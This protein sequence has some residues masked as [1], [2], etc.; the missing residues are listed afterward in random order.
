MSRLFYDICY[1]NSLHDWKYYFACDNVFDT[2]KSFNIWINFQYLTYTELTSDIVTYV[3]KFIFVNYQYSESLKNKCGNC[4]IKYV[5]YWIKDKNRNKLTCDNHVNIDK[6]ANIGASCY[7]AIRYLLDND[8]DCSFC[9]TEI[10]IPNDMMDIANTIHLSRSGDLF[11]G[12]AFENSI[13]IVNIMDKC[14]IVLNELEIK[15]PFCFDQQYSS[16]VLGKQYCYNP[17]LSVISLISL[18]FTQIKLKFTFKPGYNIKD[19]GKIY[20]LESLLN[21][22]P[23][24][25]AAQNNYINEYNGNY[26]LFAG[27]VAQY[28]EKDQIKENI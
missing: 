1:D 5:N 20:K 8:L 14:V 4:P 13:N 21:V 24:R 25:H 10:N 22:E 3:A 23:R 15:T 2:L 16:N 9:S 11:L 26:I 12:I 27:G 7:N 28:I 6:H 18:V 19:L 17:E